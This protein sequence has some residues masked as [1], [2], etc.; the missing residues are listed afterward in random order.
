MPVVLFYHPG[1]P[2]CRMVWTLLV[3]N[4]IDHKLEFVNIMNKEQLSDAFLKLNPSHTVPTM[5][6]NGFILFERLVQIYFSL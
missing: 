2:F 6:D 1:S 3:E 5:V 4:N